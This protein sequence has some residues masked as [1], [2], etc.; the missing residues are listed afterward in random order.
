MA[1][2]LKQAFKN[3][4]LQRLTRN[5]TCKQVDNPHRCIYHNKI[6]NSIARH[7]QKITPVLT[8]ERFTL[9]VGQPLPATEENRRK[10]Y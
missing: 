5:P 8:P 4:I 9:V 6:N 3:L 1:I 2:F 7:D 10:F